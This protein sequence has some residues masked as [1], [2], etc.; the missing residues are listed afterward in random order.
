MKPI[1][2]NVSENA[3]REFKVLAAREGLPVAELIRQAM[4]EYLQRQ[5]GK[6]H[7]ILDI[8]FHAS[9]KLRKKWTRAEILDEMLEK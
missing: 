6:K 7:S 2:I 3:Y 8:P 1:S 4:R 5:Q 9:G